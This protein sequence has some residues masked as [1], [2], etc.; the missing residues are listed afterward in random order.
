MTVVVV[1]QVARDLVLRVPVLP[2]AGGSTHVQERLEVL[3]G[4]GANQAVGLAQLDLPVALVG[5]PAAAG[6]GRG[7]A[8]RA[9]RR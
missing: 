9:G 2:D 3:G 4:T 6:A 7:R 1:G 8:G 5:S